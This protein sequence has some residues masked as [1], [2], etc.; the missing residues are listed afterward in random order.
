M[1]SLVEYILEKYN[2]AHKG[3][4]FY[5][6]IIDIEKEMKKFDFSR[7]I[8]YCNCDNPSFSNFY[9]FFH[10]NFDKLKIKMLL[11]TYYDDNPML[12]EYDGKEEKKTKIK[13]GDFRDNGDVMKRC[14]IVV[15]NPPF[16]QGLPIDLVNMCLKYDKDFIFLCKND[17][18]T[19]KGAFDFYKDGK[20]NV[21]NVEVG[22]FEGPNSSTKVTCY[23]FTSLP[24]K[25]N[26]FT[27]NKKYSEA[28][29]PKYKNADAIE[30]G[31][32]E[33]IPADYDGNMGVSLSF[34]KYLDRAQ[35]EIVG[36]VNAPVGLDGHKYYK[37][38]II[39]KKK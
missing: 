17:W 32:I 25:K 23:W 28:D 26:P 7:K 12:Y 3:D 10:D 9:K 15:T 30:V 4:E 1:K 6:R 21:D 33:N 20:L 38:L 24:V 34:A 13:S 35:Y 8:V 29:Y 36:I 14:D 39:K 5:T 31:A 37:R 2:N 22:K 16:S 18:Y 11:A 27:P 19:R